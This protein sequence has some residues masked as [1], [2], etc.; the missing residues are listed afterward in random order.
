MLNKSEHPPTSL[1]ASPMSLFIPLR[2]GKLYQVL[3][4]EEVQLTSSL[5]LGEQNPSPDRVC[6]L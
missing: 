1:L 5:F 6:P 3:L 4:N 2:R